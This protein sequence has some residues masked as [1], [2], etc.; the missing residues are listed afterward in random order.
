MSGVRANE[1][2]PQTKVGDANDEW[3]HSSDERFFEYYSRQSETLETRRR[4]TSI[5]DAVL[6]IA[7]SGEL[8]PHPLD[9]LDVGCGAGMLPMIWAQSGHR[10]HGVDVNRPLLELGRRRAD[11]AGLSVDL[12][13]GSADA[14]PWR[15]GSMDVCLALGFLEHVVSWEGCLDE[16]LRVL[17]P[18][19]VLFLSTTNKLCPVQQEFNLPLYSWYPSALKRRC[20]QLAASS[21]PGLANYASYPAV[22]W[23]TFYGLQ[24]SLAARGC[25][26]LDRFDLVDLSDKRSA[27]RIIIHAVRRIRALRWLAHVATPY[28]ILAAIKDGQAL[29]SRAG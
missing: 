26:S 8:A 24:S 29:S 18:A 10:A 2:G 11:E 20:E 23:F 7:Q 5:R 3:D 9:V 6:R 27:K 28:T 19:G 4:F 14:L 17:R 13:V 1:G 25:R 21:R 22:N 16:L 12:R 15:D